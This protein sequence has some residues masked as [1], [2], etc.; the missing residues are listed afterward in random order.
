MQLVG[1]GLEA[2]AVLERLLWIV[3]RAGPDHDEKTVI[4]LGD[5]AGCVLAALKD[6]LFGVCGDGDLGRK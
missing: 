6:S 3:Q 4:F 5:D 2:L 1:E